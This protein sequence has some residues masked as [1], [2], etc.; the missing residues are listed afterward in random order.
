MNYTQDLYNKLIFQ[1]RASPYLGPKVISIVQTN[2]L[3]HYSKYL[4]E[5]MYVYNFVSPYELIFAES[6]YF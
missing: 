1:S 2:V 6:L 4:L 5:C 3:C